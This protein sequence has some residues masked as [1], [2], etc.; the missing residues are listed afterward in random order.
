MQ[1][2]QHQ[3]GVTY[4][5]HPQH[6]HMHDLSHLESER[7]SEGNI[8]E[9]ES[10][11]MGGAPRHPHYHAHH[12]YYD[13]SQPSIDDASHGRG[14][15]VAHLPLPSTTT[16]VSSHFRCVSHVHCFICV[17]WFVHLN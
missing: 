2:L 3:H 11:Q 7:S 4:A 9:F 5:T 17:I 1:E 10:P 12:H 14:L 15:Q 16:G 8:S 13:N 6:Q